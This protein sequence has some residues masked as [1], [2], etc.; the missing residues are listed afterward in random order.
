MFKWVAKLF[1]KNPPLSP[2]QI[3]RLAEVY[4]QTEIDKIVPKPNQPGPDIIARQGG[5][6]RNRYH[7][8]EQPQGWP[9]RVCDCEPKATTLLEDVRKPPPFLGEMGRTGWLV[10]EFESQELTGRTCSH[11]MEVLHGRRKSTGGKVWK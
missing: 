8:Y 6:K 9:V 3:D 2:Q 5:Q 4:A 7:I 1:K 10:C 11:C